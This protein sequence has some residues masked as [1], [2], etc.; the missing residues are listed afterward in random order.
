MATFIE[1]AADMERGTPRWCSV[2]TKTAYK[3]VLAC[4]IEGMHASFFWLLLLMTTG[5]EPERVLLLQ[6]PNTASLEQV[7]VHHTLVQNLL[8]DPGVDVI[9]DRP[10]SPTL[11]RAVTLRQQ[12][13]LSLAEA[14]RFLQALQPQAAANSAGSA[15]QR[16]RRVATLTGDVLPLTEALALQATAYLW[17]GHTHATQVVLEQLLS[18]DPDYA[19][20][21]SLYN[22]A[23]QKTFR[24]SR[25]RVNRKARHTLQVHAI[26][27][28]SAI[29]V[30]GRFLGFGSGS[31]EV[32]RDAPHYIVA[33]AERHSPRAVAF[34]PRTAASDAPVEL[35]LVPDA[36]TDDAGSYAHLIAASQL[37]TAFPDPG[38]ALL[39]AWSIDTVLVLAYSEGA[40]R[41]T[42]FDLRAGQR[43]HT[44]APA[45]ITDLRDAALAAEKLVANAPPLSL[46]PAHSG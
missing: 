13:S 38:G 16:F 19:P 9:I 20:D 34:D 27:A 11:R 43:H 23:M 41:L 35:A 17:L 36:A 1:K 25:R 31:L 37:E 14:R 46:V 8:A 5:S 26:P 44:D 18:L 40:L 2:S 21:T 15:A 6:D 33:M 42:S 22:P 24:K 4:Y 3:T 45:A 32:V 10:V 30:D 29:F 7:A 39:R 28:H 12:A